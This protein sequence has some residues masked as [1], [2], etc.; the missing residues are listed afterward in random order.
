MIVIEFFE[1]VLKLGI[2][3]FGL[4]WWA[5]HR[6]YKKGDITPGADRRTVKTDLKNYRKKWRSEDKSTYGLMENKWM[7]FGGGFYGITA[8]TTFMLIE[9]GEVLN[10]L[11]NIANVVELFDD[12]IIS[13]AIQLLVNQFQNF[14]SAIT[15]FVYWAEG[16]RNFLIWI[17]V[18]Y[19]AYLL[20]ISRAAGF[21]E[22]IDEVA[23]K[24]RDEVTNH[25]KDAET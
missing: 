16:D 20:G 11:G 6:R 12:G 14:I 10:F 22:E 8:L 9:L 13:F 3:V 17:G 2:P 4:S 7:R 25:D 21:K 5:I 1:A 19:G 18:P 24:D 23:D 15:W